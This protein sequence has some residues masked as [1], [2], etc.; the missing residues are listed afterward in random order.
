MYLEDI[1]ELY[2]VLVLYVLGMTFFT[3]L[4]YLYPMTLV[5][6]IQGL[7]MCVSILK[8]NPFLFSYTPQLHELGY[9][10]YWTPYYK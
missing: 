2:D 1:L 9:G 10:S 4:P 5:I 3:S 6:L 7:F 8:I